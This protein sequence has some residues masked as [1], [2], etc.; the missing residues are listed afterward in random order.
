MFSP[1]ERRTL[2]S[3][4]WRLPARC[5]GISARYFRVSCSRGHRVRAARRA[6]A[7]GCEARIGDAAS[8]PAHHLHAKFAA[9]RQMRNAKCG[10][11]TTFQISCSRV[12]LALALIIIVDERKRKCR[13]EPRDG[14]D[15][16]DCGAPFAEAKTRKCDGGSKSLT[17]PLVITY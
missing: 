14:G 11:R 16:D 4:R 12:I 10:A 13:A 2:P 15:D 8:V 9:R 1:F 3:F 6:V 17:R 7:V 5:D